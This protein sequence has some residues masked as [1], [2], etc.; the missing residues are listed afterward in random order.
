MTNHSRERASEAML[1]CSGSSQIGT[2][3][4]IHFREQSKGEPMMRER[5]AAQEALFYSFDLERHVPPN[6]LL[7][8]IDSLVDLSDISEHLRPS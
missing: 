4:L 7:R 6:H 2:M 3:L 5:T 1:S 8:S